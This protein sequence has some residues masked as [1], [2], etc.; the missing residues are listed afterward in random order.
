VRWLAAIA[1]AA[2][3]TGETT[4]SLT[5]DDTLADQQL[6]ADALDA[7]GF[8]GTFY[9]NSPRIDQPG[10]LTGDQLAALAAHGHEIGGH[11]LDH[12]HL[13]QL[14]P[15]DA[16]HEIC[17]DRAALVARGFAV[18]SFA[19][20][21]GASDGDV[22]AIVASCG[23]TSGRDVG[24][25][26]CRDCR[27]GNAM[28]PADP[29]LVATPDSIKPDTTLASIEDVIAH[30]GGTWVPLV[31]HHVCDGCDA[32]AVSPTTLIALLDWL[33]AHHVAVRTVADVI[34]SHEHDQ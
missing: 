21:F 22:E 6:A 30:A 1:L 9:V 31:F 14:A 34:E 32:F 7:H 10:F 25:I 28:P 29:Y 12:E 23:Y 19:Y 11:T 20:P 5:F 16:Q 3:R 18:T 27:R 13:P 15:A 4:V 2:C 8:A 26:G 17:D 24:G 33:D